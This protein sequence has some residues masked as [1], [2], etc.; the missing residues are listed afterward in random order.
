ML[1]SNHKSVQVKGDLETDSI[2]DYLNSIGSDSSF[3]HRKELAKRHGI[4]N[5]RGSA[6]QNIQLLRLIRATN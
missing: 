2:V 5:Y 3:A 1:Q 6:E 4:T